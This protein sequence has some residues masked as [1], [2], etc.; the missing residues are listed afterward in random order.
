[1]IQ[2]NGS[3][4]LGDTVGTV[5]LKDG[6]GEKKPNKQQGTVEQTETGQ[7]KSTELN[8]MEETE[9]EENKPSQDQARKG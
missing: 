4:R 9:A 1:M 8:H 6:E 5:W 2:S 3:C 7:A